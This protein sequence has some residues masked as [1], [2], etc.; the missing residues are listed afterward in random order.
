MITIP[1]NQA[2]ENN[3]E[4]SI[5]AFFR[6]YHVGSILKK[7]NAYKTK[8]IPVVKI[9]IYLVQLV[10]T[11]KSMYMNI[12]NGTNKVGFG[13][14]VVYRFLNATYINWTIF[15]LSL[16][17][18]VI[19]KINKSTKDIDEVDALA[20]DDSFYGRERSKRV[21]LLA[22]VY[23]HASKG[24]KYKRGFRLL[25]IV[26]TNGKT[27]IPLIFRH[28]SSENKK[29]RYNE[30]DEKIDKRTNGYKI[31]VQ[32]IKKSTEVLIEMLKAVK[33]IGITT[34]YVLFDSWFS[35]PSTIMAIKGIGFEVVGRLKDTTKI[36][37][38]YNGQQKTLKEI[39]KMNKKRRGMSKYLLS[40]CVKIY[41]EAGE[42]M[43]A[44][45]V[46]VRNRNNRKQWIGLITTDM[47]LTEVEVIKLYGKRWGIM[48]IS[49]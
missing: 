31:R 5:K 19:S 18:A 13:K 29:N 9:V 21:E 14:D 30:I 2:K 6:K 22:N 3:L 47:T 17:M 40:V 27:L 7:S 43:D 37:Y 32:A 26:W 34:K 10:Y 8:G 16:A 12:V 41:N 42:T 44:R 20:I 11:K 23:D 38:I 25:T 33:K 4:E 28:M 45:I 39:Y 24:T 46:Y 36:K 1:E 49:A 15:M 48:P 35:Y